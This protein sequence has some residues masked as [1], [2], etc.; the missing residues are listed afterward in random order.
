MTSLTKKK[1]WLFAIGQFGWALLSGLIGSWLVYFYQPDDASIAA[2]QTVFIPQGRV[3][4]GV[5]TIIG[6]ITA[7]GRIFDA[8]T[9]PLVAS[10]SDK[11]KSPLGRR[12]P[13]LKWSALPFAVV[14]VLVF[15][16]PVNH[17]SVL[18][19]IWLAVMILLYYFSITLY[20][21]PFTALYSEITHTEEERMLAS[22]AISLTFIAGTAVAYCAPTI[23][24]ALT[25]A[26]GRVAAMRTAFVI[27][28]AISLVCMY[29]PVVSIKEKDYVD[30]VPVTTNMFESLGKTFKNKNF[31]IFVGSDIFYWIGLTMFQT[32]LSFFVT[33]L[34]KLP[35]SYFMPMFV[36]MTALSLVFYIPIN[37]LTKKF[38]KKKM[39]VLAF[40][41]F[42]VLFTF[43]ACTGPQLFISTKVQA[44][45]MVVLASFPMAI[46]GILPQAMVA[47][48]AEDDT[49]K[50]GESRQ[51][52]FFAAR[53]F[54]FK[55]GQSVAMLLFTSLATIGANSGSAGS[56]TGYR[57][58]AIVSACLCLTGGIVLVFYKDR[59]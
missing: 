23:W 13:F 30:S 47:D 21:T 3:I 43:T 26:L 53:T 28:A 19:A 29:F 37:M 5:L 11:C 40:I 36:G 14:T 38:G 44:V 57:I 6:I 51:G 27:L 10:M 59:R 2:G 25:P 15:C 56:E 1:T 32:G 18:N 52:M 58:V 42:T 24:N 20:C 22:T 33:S 46:F 50:T 31:R 9:D 7:A 48:C 16:A 4:F 49:K 8:I 45:I 34:L 41:L 17:T 12:M 39:V 35:E 54:C 55:L